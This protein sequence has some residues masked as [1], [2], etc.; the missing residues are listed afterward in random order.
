MQ[1]RGRRA[2]HNHMCDV[3]RRGH[4]QI[5]AGDAAGPTKCGRNGGAD[6]DVATTRNT[7]PL[8]VVNDT[9]GAVVGVEDQTRCSVGVGHQAVDGGG[10]VGVVET[11]EVEPDP[12]PVI[13][14]GG[15]AIRHGEEAPQGAGAACRRARCPEVAQF[16]QR[17]H[18]KKVTKLLDE[19]EHQH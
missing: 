14:S 12:R 15:G 1:L 19:I 3:G 18:A 13:D 8:V 16:Y 5:R 10:R 17:S 7:H 4:V 9:P 2:T 11:G 6:P